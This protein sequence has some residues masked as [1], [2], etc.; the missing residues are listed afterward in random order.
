MKSGQQ[1]YKPYLVMIALLLVCAVIAA[2]V[3][4]QAII[5]RDGQASQSVHQGTGW[6]AVVSQEKLLDQ[7]SVYQSYDSLYLINN[8]T[9]EVYGPF[10]RDQLT[11]LDKNGKPLGGDIFDVAITPDGKTALISS[12]TKKMIHFIWLANPAVPAY[13][14]SLKLD[15]SGYD[16]AIT[17]DS[18]YALVASSG[19]ARSIYSINI[20][21]QKLAYELVL[22]TIGYEEKYGYP[23]YG[24]GCAIAAASN[25]VVVVADSKNG[26]VHALKLRSNGALTYTSTV[27]Y[28]LSKT[29]EVSQTKTTES[30][31]IIPMNVVISPD[32]KTV[33]VSDTLNYAKNSTT[34]K[35]TNTYGLGVL[36]FSSSGMMELAKVIGLPY[37]V[38]SAEFNEDGT[39]IVMYGN[40]AG[41]YDNSANPT[42]TT[43]MDA[44][45]T[46]DV[47]AP[48]DVQ[49]NP[50]QSTLLNRFTSSMTN[51]VNALAVKNDLAYVSYPN[52]A[53]NQTLY[54]TREILIVDLKNF[55]IL[56]ILWGETGYADPV[57]IAEIPERSLIYFPSLTS[58]SGN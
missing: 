12:P 53:I 36:S 23:I 20:A 24:T 14:G 6:T 49:L 33:L 48:G 37:E 30:Q 58:G 44:I 18:Q 22:P 52:T 34:T 13:L 32:G 8:R 45:F 55:E 2:P 51:G 47:L 11:T 16:I 35:Y 4:A 15:I 17:A 5:T 27:Q 54:P 10:F 50:T 26:A 7:S 3:N 9:N 19:E 28:F 1:S 31:S 29:G 42:T 21:A 56:P 25:G 40:A 39:K 57:G 41:A 46:A 38:V 43:V